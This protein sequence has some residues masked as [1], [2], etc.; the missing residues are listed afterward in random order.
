MATD[1]TEEI[2]SQVTS[3]ASWR[4]EYCLIG[5]EDS[6]FPHQVDH[7]VS[8]KH[9]GLSTIENLALSCVLC[10][11]YKGSDI[12][13]VDPPTGRIT[14]LFNP[15]QDRWTE[16]FRIEV[17]QIIPTSS[18]G[19]VTV[20]IL[21]LNATERMAERLLLQDLGRYPIIS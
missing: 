1:L 11:R 8:R 2:R 10:N 5:E 20:L 9:G 21:K 6:G 18:V 15:R 4:C 3:R 12:A 14:Q 19:R 16:H 7:I 17:A 13:S